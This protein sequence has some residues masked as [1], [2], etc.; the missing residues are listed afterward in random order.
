M[1]SKFK[2]GD[3]EM[4]PCKADIMTAKH[5]LQ[6]CQ[7]H[8]ALRFER[9]ARTDT[10]E[11][12]ALWQPGGAKVD[13]C[14]HEGDRDFRLVYNEEVEEEGLGGKKAWKWASKA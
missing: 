14:F 10:S 2:V 9:G 1:Y 4:C 3:S 7:L 5:L 6:H 13:S 8:D 12:Q 11:G